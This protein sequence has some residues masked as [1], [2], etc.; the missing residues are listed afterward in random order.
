[1]RIWDRV[2]KETDSGGGIASRGGAPS[3]PDF[4]LLVNGEAPARLAIT[5]AP[6]TGFC[7]LLSS[8]TPRMLDVPVCPK[9]GEMV[10]NKNDRYLTRFFSHSRRSRSGM[11]RDES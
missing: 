2:G 3:P 9:T 5:R 10:S 11:L 7:V 4:V 1:M 8:T 6:G